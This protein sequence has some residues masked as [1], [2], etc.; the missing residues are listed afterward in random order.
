V[1]EG[2]VATDQ[3]EALKMRIGQYV[4]SRRRKAGLT[5]RELSRRTG[6]TATRIFN[7]EAGKSDPT[8]SA[9][10]KIAEGFGQSLIAFL[11]GF[12]S[13]RERN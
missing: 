12:Y 11:R 1:A 8:F 2:K 13:Q 9:V 6:V 3:E 4:R 5:L 7:L 10:E